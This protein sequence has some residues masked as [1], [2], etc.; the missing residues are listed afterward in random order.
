MVEDPL[1]T[2]YGRCGFGDA[3]ESHA[4]GS[5]RY[6][7]HAGAA[8]AFR[9]RRR[10]PRCHRI[11]HSLTG[12]AVVRTGEVELS[13]REPGAGS[14]FISPTLWIV[15]LI[16]PS[17]TLIPKPEPTWRATRSFT[18]HSAA[19]SAEV[20]CGCWPSTE[21]RRSDSLKTRRRPV[22]RPVKEPAAVN[23]RIFSIGTH[24]FLA[25]PAIIGGSHNGSF[26]HHP[27]AT[28][29]AQGSRRGC[30]H[31]NNGVS[32]PALRRVGDGLL[33]AEHSATELDG[34]ARIPSLG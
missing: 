24:A 11:S 6:G 8:S 7:V 21:H 20:D 26:R 10:F 29:A 13:A 32:P 16:A 23:Y 31:R 9:D 3:L 18:L 5:R 4:H 19:G 22:P 17:A 27:G 12:H 14:A 33:S 34:Q 25:I 2:V 1:S 28:P 30:S 15:I